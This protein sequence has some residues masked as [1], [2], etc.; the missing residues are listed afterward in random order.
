[1]GGDYTS[2]EFADFY[3]QQGIRRQL[4]VPYN[5]Q[6]NGVA[7]RK[8]RAIVGATRS[9]LHDQALP[10]YLWTE[11]CSTAVYLQNKSPHRALGT[12]TPKEAFT[13]SRPNVEHLGIFG[14]LTFSHVPYEKRTKM[15]PTTEKGI[16]DEQIA[17]I[18]TKSSPRGKH[19]YFWYKMGVYSDK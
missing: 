8:N 5:P 17:D 10:F 18:L 3:T 16:L 9:M 12:K 4:I 15:Y 19:V 13:G 7:K 1:M 6:Q 2:T 11:A 14:C